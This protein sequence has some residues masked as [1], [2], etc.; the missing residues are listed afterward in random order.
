MHSRFC[1]EEFSTCIHP[2]PSTPMQVSD[3]AGAMLQGSC[4]STMEVQSKPPFK[5]AYEPFTV[6][7]ALTCS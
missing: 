6:C 2:Q 7:H 4:E 1:G 5:K 3:L